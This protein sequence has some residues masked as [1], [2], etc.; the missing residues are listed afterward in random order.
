MRRLFSSIQAPAPRRRLFSS[1]QATPVRRL[2][3]SIQATPA[4]RRFSDLVSECAPPRRKFS[5]L[6]RERVPQFEASEF[7]GS[8]YYRWA[9]RFFTD[10]LWRALPQEEVD[11]LLQDAYFK[12]RRCVELYVEG[13]CTC[14]GPKHLMLIF[15][16]ACDNMLIDRSRKKQRHPGKYLYSGVDPEAQLDNSL[17]TIIG[18]A[19]SRLEIEYQE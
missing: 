6:V 18:L 5:S 1:I 12:Y 11:D 4:R 9:A 3:S 8:V 2:F 10:N 19:T 7:Y 15:K 16:R 13:G 14:R 17:L